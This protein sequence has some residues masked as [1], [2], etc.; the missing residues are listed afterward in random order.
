MD[1]DDDFLY[2]PHHAKG[3]RLDPA[4]KRI[5]IAAGGVSVLVIIV[6][7]IWSG[8]HPYDFGPPPV[9]N[10]PSTP[11]RIIPQDP[12]GLEVPDANMPIMSGQSMNNAAPHLAA[13]GV[14][15]DIAA[16]DQAA[17]LAP[18]TPP[19]NQQA[20]N[21]SSAP[22]MAA[23]EPRNVIPASSQAPRPGSTAT[24]AAEAEG[25]TSVELA[26]ANNED[27]ILATWITL[28][29]KFPGLVAGRQPELLPSIVNG[30]SVWRLRLSGFHSVDAAR[31][32]CKTLTL[33]GASCTVVTF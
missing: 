13:P 10:P 8:I 11:L 29:Q 25:L 1:S 21:T 7:W 28:K 24:S 17:G 31:D 16:L 20:A 15:P 33:Q 6:A 27:A 26:V 3:Q 18:S 19:A 2:R 30:Q 14:A 9:I 32:F 22:D 23:D 4:I 5:A 12:G